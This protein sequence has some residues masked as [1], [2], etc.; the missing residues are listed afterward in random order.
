MRA[1]TTAADLTAAIGRAR[2]LM[3]PS[4]TMLAY[5]GV[6]LA[7]DG[8]VL[9]VHASDGD[10]FGVFDVDVTDTVD[11]H[12]LLPPGPLHSWLRTLP[13]DTGITLTCDAGP[14]L[15]AAFGSSEPYKFR[16][17]NATF[18][19]APRRS[20]NPA[21]AP[22]EGFGAA[23]AAVSASTAGVADVAGKVV[24]LDSGDDGLTLYTTDT[25]R[26]TRAHLPH[27][28]FGTQS[29]LLHLRTLHTA[30][31]WGICGVAMEPTGSVTLTVGGGTITVRPLAT[32]FPGVET[33]MEAPAPYSTTF[34]TA[35]VLTVLARVKALAGGADPVVV[36]LADEH[37]GLSI[38]SE[39]TGSGSETVPV[40]FPVD[41]PARFGLNVDYFRQ[42]LESL[43]AATATLQWTSPNAPIRLAAADP[44]DVTVIVMPVS[45]A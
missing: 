7:V 39:T 11:G 1:H 32:P 26:I 18:P 19:P 8:T 6:L 44:L 41:P 24:R 4:P 27:S 42:A 33:V 43:G 25:F 38:D 20:S 12:A 29:M 3:T 5:T 23:L 2:E 22:I 13:G 17:L 37:M 28:S 21:P 16:T 9:R 15:E 40:G 31:K 45:L 35:D 36:D 10:T 14:H 34:D 30:A